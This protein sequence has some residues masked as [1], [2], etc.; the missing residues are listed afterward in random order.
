MAHTAVVG[1]GWGVEV[2]VR[3]LTPEVAAGAELLDLGCGVG[4]SLRSAE[5]RFGARGI[6][7]ELNRRK[8]AIAQEDGLAVFRADIRDVGPGDFPAARYVTF[9]NVLEHLPDL[10]AVAEVLDAACRLASRAVYIRHPSFEDEAYLAGL[11]LKQYWTDWPGAHTAHIRLHDF[12][13]IATER[14]GIYRIL[15]QP[16]LRAT[17]ASDPTLLPLSAPPG[18]RKL[19]RNGFGAY[20]AELHGPKPDVTFDRPVYFAFDVLLVTGDEVPTLHYH[21]DPETVASRPAVRFASDLPGDGSPRSRPRRRRGRVALRS[22][23][24]GPAE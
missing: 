4:R 9:D 6:G 16:V 17:D 12:V 23:G 11:G 14:L 21:S 13:R 15:I 7:L 20:S 1:A 10:D 18:Q 8:V 3:E 5:T 24:R 19:D 2:A 22:G